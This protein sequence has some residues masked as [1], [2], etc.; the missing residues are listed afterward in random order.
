[1]ENN[2]T[3]NEIIQWVL[4]MSFIIIAILA[5]VL[6]S[7]IHH[8]RKEEYCR[9]NGVRTIGYLS[10]EG[11]GAKRGSPYSIFKFEVEGITYEVHLTGRI[12]TN[13]L[14]VDERNKIPI[15]IAYDESDPARNICLPEEK[16]KYKINKILYYKK[17]KDSNSI[18]MVI[19]LINDNN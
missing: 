17:N 4:I 2:W 10:Q 19:N 3:R 13:N 8:S 15:A 7:R 18:N 14:F 5:L 1:M 11:H 12:I 9:Y 6:Y 16:I